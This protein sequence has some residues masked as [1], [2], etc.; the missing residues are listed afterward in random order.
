MLKNQPLNMNAM[1]SIKLLSEA[2]LKLLEV[3]PLSDITIS[4]LTKEAG[5]VRNTYYAHF[6]TKEDILSYHLYDLFR[7]RILEELATT[8]KEKL[9]LDHLYFD[10]WFEHLD[11]LNLLE[12]NR[13]MHLLSQFG[14]HFNLICSEF[15]LLES[16]KVSKEAESFADAV[17]ADAMASIVKTWIRLGKKEDASTLTMIFREFIS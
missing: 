12:K 5:V 7:N 8:E 6:E 16:C 4:E 3:K 17:Y 10:I 11:F 15:E 14:E 13:L 1:R 2:L 9:E